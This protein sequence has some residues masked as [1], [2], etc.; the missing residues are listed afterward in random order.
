[1]I[2]MIECLNS[3]PSTTRNR[4]MNEWIP[5]LQPYRLFL[6]ADLGLKQF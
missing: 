2:Q 6:K 1:M 3:I 5:S 4:K